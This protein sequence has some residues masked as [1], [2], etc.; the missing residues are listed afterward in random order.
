[1][2]E[3]GYVRW[4]VKGDGWEGECES[5]CV[6][7]YEKMRVRRCVRE[8]IACLCL[9]LALTGF[10]VPGGL[11]PRAVAGGPSVT[12]F[13]H[14]KCSGFNGSGMPIIVA[15]KIVTI[16]PMLQEI[17]KVTNVCMLL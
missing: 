6:R 17:K 1:M 11:N 2:G 14:N 13:T 10:I 8:Y 16:S 9:S 12:R 5:V 15:K 3:R 7:M 4:R